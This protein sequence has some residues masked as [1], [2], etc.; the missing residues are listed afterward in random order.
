MVVNWLYKLNAHMKSI[1]IKRRRKVCE[2]IS[3]DH[4][5]NRLNCY[6]IVWW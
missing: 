1:A 3:N 2:R 6:A 5:N 4:N